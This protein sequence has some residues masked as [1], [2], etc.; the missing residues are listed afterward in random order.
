MRFFNA[1][2]GALLFP[3]VEV[4]TFIIMIPLS[5]LYFLPASIHNAI[6]MFRAYGLL[7]AVAAFILTLTALLVF[8]VMN[9][10]LLTG[11]YFAVPFCW[12]FIIVSPMI[13]GFSTGWND[14][15]VAVY[16]YPKRK[17]MGI[18]D[19]WDFTKLYE[20]RVVVSPFFEYLIL[21]RRGE[22]PMVELI[23]DR[24]IEFSALEVNPNEWA[25]L[26]A[27]QAHPLT[28]DELRRLESSDGM[29]AELSA[30]KNLWSRLEVD[31]CS[32]LLERPE[33]HETVLLTKQYRGQDGRWYPVPNESHVFDKASL[34]SAL[35]I[36]DEM[37]H[38][39]T[40][41]RISNPFAYSAYPRALT[42]YVLHPYYAAV[43]STSGISQELSHQARVLREQLSRAPAHPAARA[44]ANASAPES[45]THSLHGMPSRTEGLRAKRMKFFEEGGYRGNIDTTGVLD[46]SLQMQ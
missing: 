31:P 27:E 44:E 1:I 28:P 12:A 17:L 41:D 22:Q 29:Q 25:Q 32:I 16:E 14:G 5:I 33:K 34:Q 19:Q 36:H 38:P 7:G 13:N 39:T 40:R 11:M 42:R 8:P 30:Y 18:F 15:A 9:L 23:V 24:Q 26:K 2:F 10:L 3:M 21:L 43:N 45:V 6:G 20:G 35:A 37:I 4:L 46:S